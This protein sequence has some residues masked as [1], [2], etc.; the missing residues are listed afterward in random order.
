MVARASED[1]GTCDDGCEG[2]NLQHSA[3]GG[4]EYA[5]AEVTAPLVGFDVFPAKRTTGIEP[6]TL[7]LGS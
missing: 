3:G 1:S 4:R 6:A 5:A 2:G 7:S